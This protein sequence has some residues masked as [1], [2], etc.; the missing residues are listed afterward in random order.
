MSIEKKVTAAGENIVLMDGV[1]KSVSEYKDAF[2]LSIELEN[3]KSVVGY[4]GQ[5]L[6]KPALG[7]HRFYVKEADYQAH[8]NTSWQIG[9]PAIDD[10]DP[11]A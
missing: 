4:R 6:G 11:F 3:G 2:M 1:L 9:F 10:F 5:S 8:G 7:N